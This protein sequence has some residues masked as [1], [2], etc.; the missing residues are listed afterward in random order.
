MQ[1]NKTL[2]SWPFDDVLYA[3]VGQ[4]GAVVARAGQGAVNVIKWAR[5]ATLNKE[6]K[7]YGYETLRYGEIG[8]AAG[9][10]DF[11]WQ[12]KEK[13]EGGWGVAIGFDGSVRWIED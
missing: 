11:W 6:W 10:A 7:G 12:W 8:G 2:I 13:G 9:I 4:H 3:E 5:N 1:T